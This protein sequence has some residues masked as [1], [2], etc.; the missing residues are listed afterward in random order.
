MKY[1]KQII[2]ENGKYQRKV[3]GIKQID[4][5]KFLSDNYVSWIE[6]ST[7]NLRIDNYVQY[8]KNI[9]PLVDGSSIISEIE[10]LEKKLFHSKIDDSEIINFNDRF[11]LYFE[12]FSIKENFNWTLFKQT[13]LDIIKLHTVYL[14]LLNSTKI[15]T[16]EERRMKDY[17]CGLEEEYLTK[18]ENLIRSDIIK[19]LYMLKT[20][21]IYY[22]DEDFFKQISIAMPEDSFLLAKY[23]K[24]SENS[25]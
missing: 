17:V 1:V 20:K 3:Q 10:K 25:Q 8:Y 7:A 2:S 24:I 15:T 23:L 14:Y 16:S 19:I 12:L 22:Y 4:C 9:F 5:S 18:F 13:K 11:P 6:S 21:F